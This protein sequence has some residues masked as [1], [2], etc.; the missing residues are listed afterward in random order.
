MTKFLFTISF[1]LGLCNSTFSQDNLDSLKSINKILDLV[2]NQE[3]NI[4]SDTLTFLSGNIFS[5]TSKHKFIR[6]SMYS[7][8]LV[9][10]F[11]EKDKY[12]IPI[13][14]YSIYSMN[15]M[16]DSIFDINGDSSPDLSIHWYPSSG[17][18]L[19]D[20]FDCYVYNNNT[21]RFS[22]KIEIPNPTFYP[23]SSTTF[24]MT[25]G[26]PG[27]TEFIEYKWIGL[28]MDTL[29]IY[30]WN[31]RSHDHIIATNHIK[32]EKL[33]MQEPPKILEELYGFGWF[34][35]KLKNQDE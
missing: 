30:E 13:F 23:E 4:E 27:E 9:Q 1:L 15:F 10:V 16:S 20:I 5:K 17:C 19:A 22:K 21:D 18:C 2:N 6:I 3:H 28:K 33:K 25:Y 8:A 14:S 26:H 12:K 34:M 32:G 11:S 24:S 31:D 7:E 35:M 29:N